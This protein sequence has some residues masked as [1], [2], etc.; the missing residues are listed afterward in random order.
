MTDSQAASDGPFQQEYQSHP[1]R[2]AEADLLAE[3]RWVFSR[4]SGPG[5]QNRNKVETSASIEFL[6]AKT[7]ASA[8]ER[9]TQGE[10][11]KVALQRLRCKLAIEIRMPIETGPTKNTGIEERSAFWKKYCRNGRIQISEDNWDWPALLS[12]L[13]DSLF[14]HAW[15]LQI[16]AKELDVSSSQLV[17]LL[18]KEPLALARLNSQR[19]AN[20]LHSLR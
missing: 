12:V 18:K 8:S 10:N 17:K 6:P 5:G 16:A 3:C 7:I 15:D 11:R 20:G 13:L 2:W 19:A 4:A 1:S 9:R 14:L